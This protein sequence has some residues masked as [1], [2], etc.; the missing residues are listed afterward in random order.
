M[1]VLTFWTHE[2]QIRNKFL[3]R[4][5]DHLTSSPRRRLP[6][7]PGKL[8]VSD[9]QRS[10]VLIN[11]DYVTSEGKNFPIFKDVII[12]GQQWN[13]WHCVLFS[14]FQHAYL[15]FNIKYQQ[16]DVPTYNLLRLEIQNHIECQEQSNLSS[17]VHQHPGL[18]EFSEKVTNVFSINAASA[19][20]WFTSRGVTIET[21]IFITWKPILH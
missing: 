15:I 18:G 17:C 16:L 1:T 20:W 13:L 10:W 3:W 21:Q 14:F 4:A 8:N 11:A 5:P 9:K 2:P 7:L 6:R 12:Y 19:C